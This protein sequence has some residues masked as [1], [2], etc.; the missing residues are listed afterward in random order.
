MEALMLPAGVNSILE[1]T[2][3]FFVSYK[4]RTVYFLP[5]LVETVCGVVHEY[6]TC[7]DTCFS[8]LGYITYKDFNGETV[9]ERVAVWRMTGAD[10]FSF[11]GQTSFAIDALIKMIE[12][13]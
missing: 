11:W 4:Q 3:E 6:N 12:S 13:V 5:E 7:S 1:K 2:D 8:F 9:R 10:K